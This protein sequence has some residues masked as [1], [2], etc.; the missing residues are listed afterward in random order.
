[1]GYLLHEWANHEL[2][3][4]GVLPPRHGPCHCPHCHENK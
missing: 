4:R 1:M 2:E 3:R